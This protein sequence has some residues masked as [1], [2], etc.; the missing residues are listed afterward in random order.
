MGAGVKYLSNTATLEYYPE[1]C[2]GCRR[3][4]EVCPRHVFEM[5]DKKAHITDRD[6]CMECGAC[7]NNCEYEA[8][9]VLAGV[10]CATALIYSLMQEGNMDSPSC[11]S[12][13]DSG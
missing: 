10:G 6:R 1:K 8:I 11:D 13:C 2:Q 7:A 5:K 12:C 3:C 9:K 4:T